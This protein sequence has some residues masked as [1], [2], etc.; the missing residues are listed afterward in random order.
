MFRYA[1][2]TVRVSPFIGNT[3]YA[4]QL[5]EIEE[6]VV[7]EQDEKL[8]KLDFFA[9]PQIY[10][11]I[12]DYYA[13][14]DE[15]KHES[16]W[17]RRFYRDFPH[18]ISA[19]INYSLLSVDTM[20]DMKGNKTIESLFADELSLLLEGDDRGQT[21][22]DLEY[23][24]LLWVLARYLKANNR[25]DDIKKIY[26]CALGFGYEG[27]TKDLAFLIKGEERQNFYY[28]A[29]EETWQDW[30]DNVLEEL[31]YETVQIPHFD[32]SYV[33]L[34]KYANSWT[35]KEIENILTATDLE[36]LEE[37]L[38]WVFMKGVARILR[39]EELSECVFLSNIVFVAAHHRL[40]NCLGNL[41][42]SI[43]DMPEDL[44]DHCFG[45]IV[46]EILQL[47]LSVLAEHDPVIFYNTLVNCE[48]QAFQRCILF[49]ILAYT[50]RV[51]GKEELL[52]MMTKLWRYAKTKDRELVGY[53]V[54]E[55]KDEEVPGYEEEI[56]EVYKNNLV[57]G[58]YFD[59]LEYLS[60]VT[61]MRIYDA[62]SIEKTKL[63]LMV[64]NFD[65]AITKVNN[66]FPKTIEDHIAMTFA[67]TL[68]VDAIKMQQMEEHDFI[69]EDYDEDFDFQPVYSPTPFR[70][71]EKKVGRNDSCPCGSG[72]K[73]KK[74]CLSMN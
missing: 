65:W 46:I 69:E 50:Y 53:F 45:D 40:Y 47:P 19:K 54:A 64:R 56:K 29:L 70:H 39:Q 72:K 17:V 51:T 21:F 37:D 67:D 68:E 10:R 22:F 73:Y 74:C 15:E 25:L 60:P 14:M 20:D 36:K 23:K 35:E 12:V 63:D 6:Y 30:C 13:I 48:L 27:L 1:Y 34:N 61:H 5:D 41:L 4:K 42:D 9:D 31:R 16:Y 43:F 44:F 57:D 2:P 32:L 26:H 52:S 7:E 49:K 24:Q 8:K 11:F 58:D 3:E 33:L 38:D 55:I 62:P 18:H 71:I 28:T 66:Y 59:R